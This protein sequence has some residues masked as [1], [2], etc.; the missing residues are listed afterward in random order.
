MRKNKAE[1]K[2]LHFAF[3]FACP[4]VLSFAAHNETKF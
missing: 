3:M 4:L 2:D 1:K